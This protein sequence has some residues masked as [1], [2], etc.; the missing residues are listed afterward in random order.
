MLDW[1][2]S[3]VALMIAAAVILAALIGFFAYHQAT[4]EQ[5]SLSDVS[6]DLAHFI[7]DISSR[8]S[9]I[10]MRVTFSNDVDG[11]EM[12]P[13]VNGKTYSVQ[14]SSTQV[15]LRQSGADAAIQDLIGAVHIFPPPGSSG[16][17][18]QTLQTADLLATPLIFGSGTDF[19]I[20]SRLFLAPA[21][22]YPTFCYIS[23]NMG[24]MEYA[25]GIAMKISDFN[26]YDAT[27]P[28]ALNATMAIDCEH[29]V[30]LGKDVVVV[31]G[32]FVASA[33]ISHLWRPPPGFNASKAELNATDLTNWR[34]DLS[35][36]DHLVIER[37]NLRFTDTFVRIDETLCVPA[38]GVEVFAYEG[39][40]A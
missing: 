5:E 17:D 27:D 34:L 4:L 7:N 36:G 20:E 10:R 19:Y 31:E 9:E 33:E 14:V 12:P 23:Q 30:T 1:I 18:M 21:P 15:I 22:E 3:R 38:E 24:E 25:I 35:K 2:T 26:S 39:P 29:N 13:T 32:R 8:D 40:F 28:D 11:Y 6:R 16:M 37:R